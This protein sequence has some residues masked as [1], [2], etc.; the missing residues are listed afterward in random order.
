MLLNTGSFVSYNA[1]LTYQIFPS[2]IEELYMF[3]TSSHEFLIILPRCIKYLVHTTLCGAQKDLVRP[4]I[5]GYRVL[6]VL[7]DCEELRAIR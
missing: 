1:F 2:Q 6:L 3:R 7:T 4:V 5:D